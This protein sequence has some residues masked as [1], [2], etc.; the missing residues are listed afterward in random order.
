[1]VICPLFEDT[2]LNRLYLSFS[3]LFILN[4]LI[5]LIE[6]KDRKKVNSTIIYRL[7]KSLND[8]DFDV[9][10]NVVC[11]LY[12]SQKMQPRLSIILVFPFT[13]TH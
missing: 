13:H 1:M 9:C 2:L 4:K 12:D 11:D 6:D 3:H 8:F 10:K 5:F 7:L